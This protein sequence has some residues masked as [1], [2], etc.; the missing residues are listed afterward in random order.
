MVRRRSRRG[1]ARGDFD[2]RERHFRQ[3]GV[4]TQATDVGRARMYGEEGQIRCSRVGAE[5]CKVG[6]IRE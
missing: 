2:R 3:S 5:I 6:A 1:G 4:G